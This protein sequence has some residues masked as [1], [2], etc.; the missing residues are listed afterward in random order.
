V[1]SS[2][3]TTVTATGTQS[4]WDQIHG[5]VT[6]AGEVPSSVPVDAAANVDTAVAEVDRLQIKIGELPTEVGVSFA[7]SVTGAINDLERLRVKL[8]DVE[9]AADD[10]EEAV[11][12]VSD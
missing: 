2:V 9:R 8:R 5:L 10:A 3:N 4:V 6:K 11:A 7:V 12:R 1:P